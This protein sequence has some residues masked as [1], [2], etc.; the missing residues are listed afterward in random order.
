MIKTLAVKVT[1]NNIWIGPDGRPKPLIDWCDGIQY[2]FLHGEPNTRSLDAAKHRFGFD[3][4]T[5]KVDK[6]HMQKRYGWNVLGT[7][8]RP[9]NIDRADEYFN[10]FS[11][12][13][14][15]LGAVEL[16]ERVTEETLSAAL[17]EQLPPEP[18]LDPMRGL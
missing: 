1:D 13:P 12:E 2:T 16:S 6:I 14:V 5:G 8:D 7:K 17:D 3:P 4:K 10:N 15:Y 11:I 9:G 18:P